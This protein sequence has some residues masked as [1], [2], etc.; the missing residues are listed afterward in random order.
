MQSAKS[1]LKE[2]CVLTR[3]LRF[4]LCVTLLILVTEVHYTVWTSKSVLPIVFFA[5]ALYDRYL[6]H[7]SL[8]PVDREAVV[9]PAPAHSMNTMDR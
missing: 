6:M 7:R 4:A 3:M 9:R 8:A 5:L 1:E 2:R